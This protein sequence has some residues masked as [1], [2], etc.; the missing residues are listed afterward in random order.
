MSTINLNELNQFIKNFQDTVGLPD[1]EKHHI[2]RIEEW[3][4]ENLATVGTYGHRDFAKYGNWKSA[5]EDDNHFGRADGW[6]SLSEEVPDID[7]LTYGT[8]ILYIHGEMEIPDDET[9]SKHPQTKDHIFGDEFY[10]VDKS[11]ATKH[12]YEDAVNPRRYVSWGS[13]SG[14]LLSSYDDDLRLE[15]AGKGNNL[16]NRGDNGG[17]FGFT[18]EWKEENHTGTQG[19]NRWLYETITDVAGGVFLEEKLGQSSGNGETPTIFYDEENDVYQFDNERHYFP[20][21]IVNS[22]APVSV[23]EFLEGYWDGANGMYDSD[24]PE[25]AVELGTYPPHVQGGIK[26]VKDGVPGIL[27]YISPIEDTL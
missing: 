14:D 22:A 7:H 13:A 8:G 15:E 10:H 2:A 6:Q 23:K 19:D 4:K 11:G 17:R 24:L 16:V 26:Y 20:W 27:D 18:W 5:A 3:F 1:L 9:S 25:I 12:M 21:R